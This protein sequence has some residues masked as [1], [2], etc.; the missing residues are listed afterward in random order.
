MKPL[1]PLRWQP[2]DDSYLFKVAKVI[3]NMLM[4]RE[5]VEALRGSHNYRFPVS[6]AQYEALTKFNKI[7]DDTDHGPENFYAQ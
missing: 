3:D 6:K 7:D 4:A 2:V 5:A 1:E